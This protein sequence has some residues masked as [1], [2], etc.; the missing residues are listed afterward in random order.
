MGP[1]ESLLHSKVKVRGKN[2][3]SIKD[4]TNKT[5]FSP[6]LCFPHAFTPPRQLS[7]ANQQAGTSTPSALSHDC[8]ESYSLTGCF[9]ICTVHPTVFFRCTSAHLAVAGETVHTYCLSTAVSLW[10][11][12]ALYPSQGLW[13]LF[14][15]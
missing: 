13:S 8:G 11:S 9:D 15:H 7:Q 12:F 10:P 1:L 4:A 2:I 14:W 3:H 6:V 5:P